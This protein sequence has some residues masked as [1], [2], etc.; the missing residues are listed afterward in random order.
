M[1]G[2]NTVCSIH[3]DPYYG[4]FKQGKPIA[5][6]MKEIIIQIQEAYGI[7]EPQQMK[8]KTTILNVN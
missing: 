7:E 6:I 1:P 2:G 8:T 3:M 4:E 5:E